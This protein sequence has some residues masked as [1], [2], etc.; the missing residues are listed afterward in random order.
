MD[1]QLI[2]CI[3][4]FAL[5][6]L[7]YIL[8]RIPMWVTS[9]LS[10]SALY[11]TGC[12]DAA[13]ALSG[14]SNTNTIL[15]GTMFIVASGFRRTSIVDT[16]CNGL[17]KATRGSFRMAYLGY[18]ILA[19]VL[20]NFIASPMV[21][22]AIVSP[23]LAA[24]CD[25]TGT[26]RSKMMFPM[27]VVCVSCCGILPLPTAIQMAGQ[28]SGFLETYGFDMVFQPVNF[29]IGAW[30]ILFVSILW[31]LFIG[32]KF[33]PEE[34]VL[35][36]TTKTD[37]SQKEQKKL[38]PFADK[39]GILIFFTT[40]LALIFSAQIHMATWLIALI[41]SLLMVLV[42]TVDQKAALRDIPWD[43]LMLFAGALALGT[44]LTSTGAGDA[45]GR[46]LAVAVGGTHNN[47][48][49]GALFFIIPFC[50]TQF[51]LNRAVSAVFVPIC[52]LTCQALGANPI[53]L[54]L[55]VNAGSLTAFLTPM[56]TPAVAMCMSDG[57]YDLKTIIKSGSLITLI[58]PIVYILYTMTV[59]PAF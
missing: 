19:A 15:M 16:M 52:L 32:P 10:L 48:V 56:A 57:G 36:I 50:I 14:F 13:G 12:V 33:C 55:L 27:M 43:M 5:T 9:L 8:N 4:I 2:I 22:Y 40:I 41:G 47:Y 58:L 54:I 21:V 7:S 6:L 26:S 23:L 28:F 59:F 1:I 34:P 51:M 31:A 24:L 44:G 25:N 49:L 53:G 35:P 42:G 17:M 39:A 3:V 11:V 18:L 46:W 45:I 30:P 38:S 29:L 20:T 37:K